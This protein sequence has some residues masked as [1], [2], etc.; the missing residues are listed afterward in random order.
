MKNII[1]SLLLSLHIY[2]PLAYAQ[3]GASEKGNGGKVLAIDA[4]LSILDIADFMSVI[5]NSADFSAIAKDFR[6]QI[7]DHQNVL[8]VALV[9]DRKELGEDNTCSSGKGN[10]NI[11]CVE[12]EL[13]EARKTDIGL[14]Y[15]ILGH[16]ALV[17]TG[18][19]NKIPE[20]GSTYTYSSSFAYFGPQ[21]RSMRAKHSYSE[22]SK[23]LIE[24]GFVCSDQLDFLR[25][26]DGRSFLGAKSMRIVVSHPGGSFTYLKMKKPLFAST[27]FEEEQMWTKDFEDQKQVNRMVTKAN[28]WR[29]LEMMALNLNVVDQ[30]EVLG[31][32]T[33]NS[34]GY[35]YRTD[36]VFTKTKNSFLKK[37]HFLGSFDLNLVIDSE[38]MKN[39]SHSD[40]FTNRMTGF[41]F[42]LAQVKNI[43]K[44]WKS[45]GPRL[46]CSAD[47]NL[48][49]RMSWVLAA[50]SVKVKDLDGKIRFNSH[51]GFNPIWNRKKGADHSEE[52]IRANLFEKEKVEDFSNEVPSRNNC[53]F[54]LFGFSNEV[55]ELLRPAL[56]A[57]GYV[58]EIG[59]NGLTEDEAQIQAH[60]ERG[61]SS[62][63][64]A[65]VA[66]RASSNGDHIQ[67]TIDHKGMWRTRQIYFGGNE[68]YRTYDEA[69][70]V[71][72][73]DK[74]QKLLLPCG[75]EKDYW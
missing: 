46:D 41:Q 4:K 59:K 60:E 17:I 11:R 45:S 70:S 27:Y 37:L 74:I 38:W 8:N 6:T 34:T 1:F 58:L 69:F 35:F 75:S 21:I 29:R 61:T 53:Y 20:N 25:I 49:E 47:S 23:S 67:M 72:T 14:Y 32:G 7:R 40:G 33:W 51:D 43:E 18:Y 65:I 56:K 52:T 12:S 5:G 22:S 44:A 2:H 9:R 42:G 16:E 64:D 26:R 48:Y 28:L 39:F 63:R 13:A 19:E 71:G 24:S 68:K 55:E 62:W 57:K 31:Q 3:S 36:G 15:S 10:W 66:L 73:I 30:V 50:A 54:S